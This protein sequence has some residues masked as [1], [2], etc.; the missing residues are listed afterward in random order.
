MILS[1]TNALAAFIAILGCMWLG[2]FCLDDP[3]GMKGDR[4]TF[5]GLPTSRI[6]KPLFSHFRLPG[7]ALPLLQT[8]VFVPNFSSDFSSPPTPLFF[9]FGFYNVS[10]L[11]DQIQFIFGTDV[12]KEREPKIPLKWGCGHF[13]L[14]F[15]KLCEGGFVLHV[16]RWCGTDEQA[17]EESL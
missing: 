15:L 12:F 3:E 1:S 11:P 14:G 17:K 6:P 7:L 9:L 4:K 5:G 8:L 16:L 10:F 13:L 2:G